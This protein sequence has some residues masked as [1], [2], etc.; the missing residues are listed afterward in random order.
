MA[1]S[2]GWSQGRADG[3]AEGR[4]TESQTKRKSRPPTATEAWFGPVTG[5]TCGL[6][7]TQAK[8]IAI[9]EGKPRQARGPQIWRELTRRGCQGGFFD[10]ILSLLWKSG[11]RP[12]GSK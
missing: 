12:R 4:A 7:Q 11:A 6:V 10:C 2:S 5:S 8:I 3:R 1:S 9:V